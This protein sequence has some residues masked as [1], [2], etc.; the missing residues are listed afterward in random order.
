M[1][2]SRCSV[3]SCLLAFFCSTAPILSLHNID[4]TNAPPELLLLLHQTRFPWNGAILC[5]TQSQHPD[6][7]KRSFITSKTK[8]EIYKKK[9]KKINWN[10]ENTRQNTM[11][12]VFRPFETEIKK[13]DYEDEEMITVCCSHDHSNCSCGHSS[14][15][16]VNSS[17]GK[18]SNC[19]SS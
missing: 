2:L 1:R 3:L 15:S 19:S 9:F 11:N 16:G 18:L 13:T 14:D 10:T 8:T 5:K 7:A 6:S 12:S 4:Q 17:N